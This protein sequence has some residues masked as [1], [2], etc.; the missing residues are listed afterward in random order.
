MS[1]VYNDALGLATGEYIALLSPGDRLSQHALYWLAEEINA[2]PGAQLIYSDADRL[3]DNGRRHDP[4][5]KS[6]W[7]PDL[8]LS[9]NY[10]GR[11]AAYRSERIR[12][13]GS[14]R[15]G[16]EGAEDWNLVL[17]FTRALEPSQ[18][19]HIP[20]ILYHR[21]LGSECSRGQARAT[22]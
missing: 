3:D 6:D 10:V 16:V 1:H 12:E 14:F 4:H 7:N 17:R 22:R 21:R 19:H 2:H 11:L 18:I 15:E 9:Q 20:Q 8:L 5:F 13:I